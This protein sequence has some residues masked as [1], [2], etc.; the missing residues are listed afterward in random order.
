MNSGVKWSRFSCH[1]C[2]IQPFHLHKCSHGHVNMPH[3][4]GVLLRESLARSVGLA[5][6]LTTH[7]LQVR[8]CCSFLICKYHTAPLCPLLRSP[9]LDLRQGASW[10]NRLI[11][12]SF[13]SPGWCQI[14]VKAEGQMAPAIRLSLELPCSSL[15]IELFLAENLEDYL[16]NFPTFSYRVKC[17]VIKSRKPLDLDSNSDNGT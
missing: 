16:L 17:N 14:Q 8:L 3:S 5:T 15:L 4:P 6:R 12:L 9:Q 7:P 2:F 1:V 13:W 10:G 11:V